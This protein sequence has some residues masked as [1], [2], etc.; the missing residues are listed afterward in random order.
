MTLFQGL[1]LEMPEMVP[2]RLTQNLVDGFGVS[3]YEGVFRRCAEITLQ[4]RHC[5]RFN[6]R[7]SVSERWA[8]AAALKVS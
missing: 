6:I 1:T 2:F 3:G 8:S 5:L 4:A 7:T